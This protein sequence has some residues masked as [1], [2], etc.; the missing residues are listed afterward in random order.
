MPY[1][2]EKL[3]GLR[4]KRV[5][6]IATP[7]VRQYLDAETEHVVWKIKPGDTVLDLGCGYGRVIPELAKKA[8]MVIG[9]DSSAESLHL[10]REMLAGVRNHYLFCMDVA[11]LGFG[12]SVFD[13]VICIQNGISAFHVD[14][15]RLIAESMRVTKRG[16]IV[17]FSSYTEKF[18]GHRLSW[19]EEQA[20]EGLLGE[21][22]YE[23]TG[24]GVIV[25]NDGFTATTVDAD[26]F[27]SLTAGLHAEIEIEEID[28]SSLFCEI[29]IR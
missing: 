14:Q 5:Y 7:R 18:W 8:G 9:I 16:G 15:S 4:L 3:S 26:K 23:K 19:F 13:V 24:D 22:D 29:K 28:D 17:L 10:G 27:R 11:A 2:A 1:Y 20:K 25:C 12:E 6:D 21:I